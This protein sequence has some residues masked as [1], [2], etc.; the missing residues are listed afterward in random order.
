MNSIK[1]LLWTAMLSLA[2]VIAFASDLI[3]IGDDFG[4]DV[5]PAIPEPSSALMMAA[6]FA[7]IVAVRRLRK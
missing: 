1:L 7:T 2:P 5:V 3:E 4:D 6:G